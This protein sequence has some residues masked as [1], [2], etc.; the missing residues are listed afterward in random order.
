MNYNSTTSNIYRQ[1]WT[2]FLEARTCEPSFT[3]KHVLL[4]SNTHV[5]LDNTLHTNKHY[6]YVLHTINFNKSMDKY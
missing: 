3:F 6:T 2:L 1:L 5:S 4:V